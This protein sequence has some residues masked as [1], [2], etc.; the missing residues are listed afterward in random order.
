MPLVPDCTIFMIHRRKAK[1]NAVR[2]ILSKFHFPAHTLTDVLQRC[3]YNEG[4]PPRGQKMA[5]NVGKT[6][7][8]SDTMLMQS[9]KGESAH[10]MDGD[11]RK[12][13]SVHRGQ[14][15][16]RAVRGRDRPGGARIAVLFPEGLRHALRHDGGR[17][18]PQPPPGP[19]RRRARGCGRD[20]AGHCAEVRLRFAGQLHPGLHALPRRY[21]R[22]RPPQQRRAQELC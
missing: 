22:R 15:R 6:A 20:G 11:H 12:F 13:D 17:I 16:G 1:I 19:G 14:P 7:Q 4:T 21:A 5:G 10:G 9:D 18:H 8:E 2:V 3:Y